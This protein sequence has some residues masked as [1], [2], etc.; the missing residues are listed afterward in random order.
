MDPQVVFEPEP[1][2]GA[3]RWRLIAIVLGG[4]AITMAILLITTLSN[5]GGSSGAASVKVG[6]HQLRT[7]STTA[8]QVTVSSTEPSPTSVPSSSTSTTSQSVVVTA[9]ATPPTSSTPP[10]TTVNARRRSVRR[11]VSCGQPTISAISRFYNLIRSALWC[12][13]ASPQPGTCGATTSTTLPSSRQLTRWVTQRRN[14]A[15]LSS[16]LP[17]THSADPALAP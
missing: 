12:R 16:R 8:M 17:L 6:E 13:P 11:P 1:G 14:L 3:W 9:P 5:S 15:P 7:S 4:V 2:G 10:S